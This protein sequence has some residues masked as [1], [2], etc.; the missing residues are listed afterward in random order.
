VI[1]RA[2]KTDAQPNLLLVDIGNTRVALA[3]W[4][5][6]TRGQAVHLLAE[7]IEPVIDQLRQ[8]WDRL[9]QLGGQAGRGPGAK[10]ARRAVVISS[11]CPP[12]LTQIRALC[13]EQSIGPLLVVGEN[14][15][16]P[17]QADV[18]EPDKVGTDRLCV[19]AAAYQRVKGA[20]VVADFGTALTIDLVSDD[21]V[22]L[23]GT[24]LPGMALC[25]QALHEHTALLPLVEIGRPAETLGK[26]TVSA[27]RNGVFAMMA[28]AL[29]EVV[30]RYATDIG[31]W[32][33]LIVTGG[34]ASAVASTCEFIDRVWPD[35]SLDGL[36]IAY[37][38]ATGASTE[39]RE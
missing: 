18:P 33:T 24:I 8:Q 1:A 4:S 38:N 9:A 11:V 12:T 20:C 15:G 27:I 23:G 39:A 16:L 32:P 3:V 2:P 17:I 21:G 7:R 13:Q 31:K 25:A 26:D 6:G 5:K 36:V 34:D 35:L 37:R 19:A 22:F 28:G 14:L 30:E 29:R 10:P